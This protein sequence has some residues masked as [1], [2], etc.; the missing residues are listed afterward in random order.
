MLGDIASIRRLLILPVA[1]M[2]LATAC[3][4]AT[5]SKP[6]ASGTSTGTASAPSPTPSPTPIP[7][8]VFVIVLENTSYNVALA[9]P[10]TASLA[11]QY[12]VATNYQDVGTPS[13]PN[14]LAM[15][16]GTT[17]GIHDDGYHVL[18]ATG[19]GTQLT[20]AGVSWK[21]Y[22]EGFTGDCFNSPY[23]YALKHNPFAYYG[24]QCPANVVPMSQLATDL[25]GNTPQLSW[26]TPGLCNDGHDCGAGTADR[27]LSQMVP[28]ITAS[29]AWQQNGVLLITW[30]ESGAGSQ[31]ALLA[32]AP[33]LKG[34]IPTPMNHYSLLATV[35]DLLGVSRLA[36]AQQASSIS[37]QITGGSTTSTASG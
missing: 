13:L 14:Y 8:H 35:E 36:L 30:D 24:G 4:P 25:S 22:F 31:V 28:Q 18:P 2:V 17:F 26:I 23:P 33:N 7:R 19:I 29:Q 1:A 3:Q 9:Q 5:S 12:A 27:W 15:T 10:Y 6:P 37:K 20:G 16:A 11:D 32:V 21:A 34:A